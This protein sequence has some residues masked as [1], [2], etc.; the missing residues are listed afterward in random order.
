MY[1]LVRKTGKNIREKSQTSIR[2]IL[3]KKKGTVGGGRE[4]QENV[5]V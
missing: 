4:W 5:T 3:K 2:A 1:E